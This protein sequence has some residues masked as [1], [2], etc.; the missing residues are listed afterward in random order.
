MSVLVCFLVFASL[1]CLALST[2]KHWRFVFG[3]ALETRLPAVRAGGWI[4]LSASLAAS[5]THW[6][7]SFGVIAWFG[8]LFVSAF[9]VTLLMTYGARMAAARLSKSNL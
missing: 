5:V 4:M 3:H 6:G 7:G 2:H 1:G 8:I 9:A